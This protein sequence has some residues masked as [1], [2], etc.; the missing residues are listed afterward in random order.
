MTDEDLTRLPR[1]GGDY[2]SAQSQ[3]VAG[4]DGEVAEPHVDRFAE[5]AHDRD[6]QRR[7]ELARPMAAKVARTAERSAALRREM[8]SAAPG[9]L[10]RDAPQRCA[11]RAARQTASLPTRSGSHFPVRAPVSLASPPERK[12]AAT[13]RRRCSALPGF[14]SSLT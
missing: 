14:V 13:T 2:S 5:D 4:T 1:R 3:A 12:E 7:S 10:S 11:R 6:E 8:T 9:V